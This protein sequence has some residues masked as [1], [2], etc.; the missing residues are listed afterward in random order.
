MRPSFP[1]LVVALGACSERVEIEAPAPRS[2]PTA[3]WLELLDQAATEDGVNYA[4]I[5]QRRTLLH[6]YLAWVGEHGPETEQWSEG[7][8]RRRLAYW[9]NAYNAAVIEGVLRAGD[10]DSVRDVGG[11]GWGLRPGAGFF[12]GQK[13][14]VDG[15]WQTLYVIEEQDIINRYQ[16]PLAHVGL[17]CASRSCPPLRTWTEDGMNQD[18]R[19][20]MRDWLAGDG[21]QC[22]RDGCRASA[23]FSWHEADFLDWSQADNLCQW[24]KPYTSGEKRRWMISHAEDCRLDFL[25]FDW[26]LNA[27]N[28]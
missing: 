2:D 5:D 25:P 21:L 20:A 6:Q 11:G 15:D 19:D 1:V 27:R 17:N 9:F 23:I 28:P 10:I 8:Q 16:E 4:M 26:S 7:A 22:D 13:F 14:H 18:M 3:L 12:L 24:M